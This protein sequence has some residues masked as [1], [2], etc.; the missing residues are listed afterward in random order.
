MLLCNVKA[1]LF[2]NVYSLLYFNKD[3]NDDD[4]SND[5]NDSNDDDDD[6]NY[7]GR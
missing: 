2:N 7:N 3:D 5:D 4:D 1:A 6:G